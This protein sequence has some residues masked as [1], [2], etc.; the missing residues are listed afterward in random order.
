[1]TLFY[2]CLNLTAS[3]AALSLETPP[4]LPKLIILPFKEGFLANKSDK[5]KYINII[6]ILL[7]KDTC[8]C[9]CGSV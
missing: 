9:V 6:N 7:L 4:P 5:S 2:I 3:V 1:M 8:V